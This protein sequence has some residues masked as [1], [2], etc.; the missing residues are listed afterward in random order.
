[1]TLPHVVIL[2]RARILLGK[3]CLR[4]ARRLLSVHG[5]QIAGWFAVGPGLAASAQVDTA[6][7]LRAAH[8]HLRQPGAEVGR[9]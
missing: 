3:L 4:A 5:V 6:A 8:L 1:M 7:R 2:C 9:C